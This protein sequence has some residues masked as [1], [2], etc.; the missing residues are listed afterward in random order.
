MENADS[1]KLRLLRLT[2][3]AARFFNLLPRRHSSVSAH[4]PVLLS[5][6]CA[7]VVKLLLAK[8]ELLCSI[9]SHM[10]LI[11]QLLSLELLLLGSGAPN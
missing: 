5:D 3:V 6:L 7:S 4:R 1:V 2:T 8:S 11:A 9:S 10:R